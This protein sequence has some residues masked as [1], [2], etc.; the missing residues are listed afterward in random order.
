MS[1]AEMVTVSLPAELLA[2]IER[3]RHDEEA[4]RSEVVS[5][6]LWS[7][8]RQ[9]EAEEREERSRVA[10]Q[11]QLETDAEHA[12]ADE[13]AKDHFGENDISWGDDD[14]AAGAPS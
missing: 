14:Q 9:V 12:W 5:E 4:S 7:G 13:A 8:W 1:R 2:R 11:I 10:Y 3:R 6:L